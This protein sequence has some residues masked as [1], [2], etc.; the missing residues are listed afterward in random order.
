MAVGVTCFSPESAT[1]SWPGSRRTRSAGP[2]VQKSLAESPRMISLRVLL[3]S[4]F[5]RSGDGSLVLMVQ[6]TNDSPSA[7]ATPPVSYLP[8]SGEMVAGG[9]AVSGTGKGSSPAT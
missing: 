7:T 5:G 4:I 9:V 6:S 2:A 1:V 3:K 8:A